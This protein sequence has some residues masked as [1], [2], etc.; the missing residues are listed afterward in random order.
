[1]N[2]LIVSSHPVTWLGLSAILYDFGSVNTV[3]MCSKDDFIFDMQNNPLPDI[4][5]FDVVKCDISSIK[6]LKQCVNYLGQ[7]K[8]FVNALGGSQRF[9]ADS[10][11]YSGRPY[12][13][14]FRIGGNNEYRAV[15]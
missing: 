15:F 10:L 7:S 3:E 14:L 8:L 4:I 12:I 6:K 13:K 11:G 2:A 1:M 5:F 9:R